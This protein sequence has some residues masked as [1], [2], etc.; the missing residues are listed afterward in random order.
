MIENIENLN[1]EIN[2][3]NRMCA[4][5]IGRPFGPA[6]ENFTDRNRERLGVLILKLLDGVLSHRI[7]SL[8]E[9]WLM[10]DSDARRYYIDFVTLTTML[11]VYYNPGRFKLPKITELANP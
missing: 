2:K 11:Q 8:L 9:K 5:T 3:L 1:S 4:D 10:A 6:P 7:L